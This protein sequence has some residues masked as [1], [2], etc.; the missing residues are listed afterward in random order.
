MKDQR[1]TEIRVGITVIIGI[2]IFLWILG[3]AKNISI[4]SD[5]NLLTVKFPNVDGLEIGDDVTINGVRQGFVED[6]TIESEAVLVN[7]N[8]SKNITLKEDA[9]FSVAMLDLMG[10]KKIDIH[11]GLSSNELDYSKTHEGYFAADI[12]SVMYM[13]GKS[14]DNLTT[15]L[16]ELRISLTSMNEYLTDKELN[17]DI[18]SS[19]SGLN[20][21][22]VKLNQILDD[23][24]Q[25]IKELTANSVELTKEANEFIKT[26]KEAIN[27]SVENIKNLLVKADTLLTNLNSLSNELNSKENNLNKLLTD[28]KIYENLTASIAQLKELTAIL[29]QQLKEDGIKVD[30]YIF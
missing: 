7:I 1:K 5:H 4:V 28:P 9:K 22:M 17:A 20:S 30:A 14:Q 8:L 26:N 21:S 13:L 19:I 2:I 12:P 10:G 16:K 6:F 23:N 25:G 29:V 27:I 24:R 3:W 18:K 11:P 15:I